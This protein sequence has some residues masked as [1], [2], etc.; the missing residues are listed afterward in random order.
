MGKRASIF[1]L[2][3]ALFLSVSFQGNK[4]KQNNPKDPAPKIAPID[5][6]PAGGS[7]PNAYEITTAHY[8]FQTDL[9]K[10]EGLKCVA[11]L[12]KLV[13]FLAKELK[14]DPK[15]AESNKFLYYGFRDLQKFQ[16]VRNR[17]GT[18]GI[19]GVVVKGKAYCYMK[20]RGF[21]NLYWVYLH[22]GTHQI[23]DRFFA[24]GECRKD[25]Y[26]VRPGYWVVEGFACFTGS[27]KVAGE[28][29]FTVGV[30][31]HAPLKSLNY[32]GIDLNSYVRSAQEAII[33]NQ[34]PNYLLGY[35]LCHYLY[36]ADNGKYRSK[37]FQYV[38]DIHSEKGEKDTFEKTIGDQASNLKEGFC[39][40]ADNLINKK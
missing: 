13:S 34:G 9:P 30:E 39:K 16:E 28:N 27:L 21:A 15:P 26:H 17:I 5:K 6:D 32:Q 14:F 37:F 19:Y 12:E 20:G 3:L 29:D 22:E 35:L 1:A 40:Y 10:E 23:L 18:R 11:E 24:R 36:F 2:M 7:W 8:Q 25:C 38:K 33:A 4:E 31:N